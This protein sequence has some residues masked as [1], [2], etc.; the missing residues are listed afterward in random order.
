M[1]QT[2]LLLNR[3]NTSKRIWKIR[4]TFEGGLVKRENFVSSI[5]KSRAITISFDEQVGLMRRIDIIVTKEDLYFISLKYV[6]IPDQFSPDSWDSSET[7]FE[8][9]GEY[10]STNALVDAL[11]DFIRE[12]FSNWPKSLFEIHY[13]KVSEQVRDSL[14]HFSPEKPIVVCVPKGAHF[15]IFNFG[16]EDRYE[17]N[18]DIK[19]C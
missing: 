16:F 13:Y 11:E 6:G 19:V 2:P 7:F 8:L 18:L 12:P 9:R 14:R 17:S 15:K 3:A 5:A 10:E 4:A 1:A